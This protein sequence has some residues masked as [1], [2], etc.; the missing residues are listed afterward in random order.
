VLAWGAAVV[1]HRQALGGQRQR[2]RVRQEREQ[3]GLDLARPGGGVWRQGDDRRRRSVERFPAVEGDVQGAVRAERHSGRDTLAV[4][5]AE[6]ARGE[7]REAGDGPDLAR[8]VDVQ[9][10]VGRSVADVP[11][12]G[13]VRYD[14]VGLLGSLLLAWNASRSTTRPLLQRS[15]ANPALRVVASPIAAHMVPSA[16]IAAPL[17]PARSA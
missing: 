3:R 4:A 11:A 9:D 5:I 7:A 17:G 12:L 8:T 13:A 10:V 2:D 16:A 6:P 15:V 1:H 14:V